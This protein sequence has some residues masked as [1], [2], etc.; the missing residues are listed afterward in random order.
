V[1][2]FFIRAL[3]QAKASF[4]SKAAVLKDKDVHWFDRD[5]ASFRNSEG[6]DRTLER[7]LFDQAVAFEP[8][9]YHFYRRYANLP[10]A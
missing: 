5:D 10:F 9:Y 4:S 8:S 7:E 6:W 2:A 3:A 1:E